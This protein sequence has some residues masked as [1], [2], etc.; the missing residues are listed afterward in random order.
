MKKSGK[1]PTSLIYIELILFIYIYIVNYIFVLLEKIQS[2]QTF[3]EASKEP[4]VSL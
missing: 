2:N 4:E 1:K 3:L